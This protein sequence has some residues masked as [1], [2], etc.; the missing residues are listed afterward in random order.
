M[1]LV[2]KVSEQICAN[3]IPENQKSSICLLGLEC[4]QETI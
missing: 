2:T 3:K 4:C 1:Y